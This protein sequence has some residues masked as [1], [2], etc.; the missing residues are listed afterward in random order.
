LICCFHGFL[1][2]LSV[3]LPL[4]ARLTAWGDNGPR[5]VWSAKPKNGTNMSR[6]F[7]FVRLRG[8]ET[9]TN[10]K[11]SNITIKTTQVAD[12]WPE[13]VPVYCI[14]NGLP[15]IT[16]PTRASGPRAYLRRLRAAEMAAWEQTGGDYLLSDYVSPD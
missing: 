11:T 14:R 6:A 16:I 7:R 2:P 15:P 3:S 4:A 5:A 13:N 12:E 9:K 1:K 10:M 8:R